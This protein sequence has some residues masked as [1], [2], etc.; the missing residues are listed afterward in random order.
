MAFTAKAGYAGRVRYGSGSTA[1]AGVRKWRVSKTAKTADATHFESTTDAN[2][3]VHEAFTA[4]TITTTISMEGIFDG[5]TANT[6][7][8]IVPG[9]SYTLDLLFDRAVSALGYHNVTA[10]CTNFSPSQDI[11][12]NAQF[13]AEFLVNGVMPAVSAAA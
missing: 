5:D 11:A 6:D 10:I 1:L 12:A 8:L 13:S 9:S 7:S 3:M 2:N 4:G